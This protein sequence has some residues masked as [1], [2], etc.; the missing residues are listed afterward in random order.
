MSKYGYII[1]K[2]FEYFFWNSW[3]NIFKYIYL[4][5]EIIFPSFLCLLFYILFYSF[6]LIMCKLFVV[7]VLSILLV[8]LNLTSMIKIRKSLI[9][10]LIMVDLIKREKTTMLLYSPNWFSYKFFQVKFRRTNIC[11]NWNSLLHP[12]NKTIWTIDQVFSI[13]KVFTFRVFIWTLYNI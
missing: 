9:F 10:S 11:F 13:I 3:S 1:L 7:S 12:P 6:V 5:H 2:L 4:Y 8:F